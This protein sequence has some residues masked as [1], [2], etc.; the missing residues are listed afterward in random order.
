MPGKRKRAVIEVSQELS[1]VR[2]VRRRHEGTTRG[3]PRPIERQGK[4]GLVSTPNEVIA[5][6][7]RTASAGAQLSP[8]APGAARQPLGD[9]TNRQVA[10]PSKVNVQNK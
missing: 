5:G 1:A 3:A 9:I 4:Y 8:S 7:L 6:H 2:H 10:G